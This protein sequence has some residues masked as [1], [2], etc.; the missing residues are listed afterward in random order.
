MTATYCRTAEDEEQDEEHLDLRV[1]GGENRDG[2]V[3][4]SLGT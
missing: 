2:A 4:D 3:C 1:E